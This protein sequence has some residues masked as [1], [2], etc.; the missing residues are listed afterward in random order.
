MLKK[1]F[2]IKNISF[3]IFAVTLLLI[4]P[5]ITGILMLFFASYVLACALYPYVNKLSKKMNKQLAVITVLTTSLMGIIAVFVPILV[6]GI[7]EVR[8]FIGTI[9]LKLVIVQNYLHNGTIFGHKLIKLIDFDSIDYGSLIGGSSELAQGI[10]NQSM[11][12]TMGIFQFIVM[13]IAVSMIVL[14]ILT[15]KEYLKGKFLELF[16]PD[17]KGKAKNIL[18][19]ISERVGGYVRAQILSMVSI[20][21]MVSIML[22]ILGVE[23]PL[24]LG[25]ISG[26]MDIVPL[27]GPAIALVLILVSAYHLGWIKI[28]LI[29]ALF[30]LIQQL[31]NYLIR[32]LL[33]GKFMA[34]H[35]L[36][37]FL[38]LFLAEQFLGFWGVLL[39]PAI[40][41]TVCILIDELYIKPINQNVDL[42]KNE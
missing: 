38:A 17:L 40:A 39:S 33:F 7:N 30:L 31:S 5:K 19:S 35:P 28:I 36:T 26:V 3:L 41:A 13:M 9:P 37:I 14:Y 21:I 25:L 32:P 1:F 6:I 34:L 42:Q 12:F 11:N 20:G 8:N 24:I 4:I 10:F 15:D 23:Y 18:A 22:L 2:T 27:L 16:P 29:I